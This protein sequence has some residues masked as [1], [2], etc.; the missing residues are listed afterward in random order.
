MLNQ[1][2]SLKSSL[3]EYI[4]AKPPYIPPPDVSHLYNE[5]QQ[6]LS[7]G[8]TQKALQQFQTTEQIIPKDRI[9]IF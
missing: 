9:C 1:L 3:S 8:Q 6:F 4:S 5:G 7:Q 2:S